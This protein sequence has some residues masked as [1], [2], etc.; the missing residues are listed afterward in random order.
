[1][2]VHGHYEEQTISASEKSHDMNGD[3]LYS[4]DSWSKHTLYDVNHTYN[5]IPSGDFY[6]LDTGDSD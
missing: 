5:V 6:R 1:M 2:E 3:P 4:Y